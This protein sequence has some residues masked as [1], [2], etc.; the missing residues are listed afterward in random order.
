MTLLV[1]KAMVSGV[2]P[3]EETSR[4][5]IEMNQNNKMTSRRDVNGII[6]SKGN[7][8]LKYPCISYFQMMLYVIQPDHV[9]IF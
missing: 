9:G 4:L 7:H 8:I 6:V 5:V 1:S 3:I 2:P